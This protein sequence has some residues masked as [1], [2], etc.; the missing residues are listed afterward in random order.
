MKKIIAFAFAFVF[1]AHTAFA[2]EVITVSTTTSTENSGLLAYILPLFTEDTGIEVR[3]VSKG[4]GAAIADGMDGNVDAIMVHDTPRE[5]EFVAEGYGTERYYIMYNDFVLIGPDS[6]P[7]NARSTSSAEEAFQAIADSESFFISRGD[8]SGT[9]VKEAALWAGT[10]VELD[11]SFPEFGGWYLSVGQGMGTVINMTGEK[12]GYTLTD[13]A[14]F[15]SMKLADPPTTE[16]EIVSEGYEN[17]LNPYGYIPVNPEKY[18]HVNH[19]AA[20][21]LG[22]WLVSA[23]GIEAIESFRAQ[24]QQLFF[25]PE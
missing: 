3:I 16:L 13:R 21:A 10:S 18:P 8:D 20:T 6:D 17:L 15:Y 19:E 14:T 9:H 23:A 4:T 1:C 2:T 24:G 25:V 22:E 12:L 11:G 5:E 7:A